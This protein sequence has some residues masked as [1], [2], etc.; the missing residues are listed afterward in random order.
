MLVKIEQ[1]HNTATYECNR[2][3]VA[4]IENKPDE[5]NITLEGNEPG[6]YIGMIADKRNTLMYVMNNDGKTVDSFTWAW[7]YPTGKHK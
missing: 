2:Y 6:S 7:A 1:G 5:V 3:Y 4:P